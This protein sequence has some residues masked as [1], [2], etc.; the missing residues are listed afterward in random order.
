MDSITAMAVVALTAGTAACVL[1]KRQRV[2]KVLEAGGQVR[3]SKC[4]AHSEAGRC[5]T[6]CEPA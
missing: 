6:T 4:A 5:A 2:G 3:V 1:G